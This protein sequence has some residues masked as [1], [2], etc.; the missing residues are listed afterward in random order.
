MP[1]LA[2]LLQ[3]WANDLRIVGRTGRHASNM[4]QLV[5]R[6]AGLAGVTRT[7]EFT[8][9]RAT[10]ALGTLLQRGR[11]RRTVDS[12]RQALHAFGAW[13][14]R[15]ERVEKSPWWNLPRLATAADRTFRRRALTDEEI[16]RLLAVAD[17]RGR[18][19]WYR[20]GLLAGL[21]RSEIRW[22]DWSSIDLAAGILRLRGKARHRVDEL[23]LHPEILL[24]LLRVP[25]LKRTGRVFPTVPSVRTRLRDFERAGIP[26]KDAQGRIADLHA[27]RTTLATR[28]AF[29]AVPPI[30]TM[31]LLRHSR[32]ET[33]LAHYVSY[34][35]DP[36]REA[37]ARVPMPHAYSPLQEAA[38]VLG[39]TVHVYAF[40]VP[41]SG[42]RGVSVVLERADGRAEGIDLETQL[43]VRS[44]EEILGHL[45]ALAEIAADGIDDPQ[46]NL[47]APR[48]AAALLAAVLNQTEM[49]ELTRRAA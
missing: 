42:W 5:L 1:E 41:D 3:V 18:G 37:L 7:E 33:T 24:R 32:I 16:S 38:S 13:L 14:C 27:L 29:S 4:E 10:T 28:L 47:S 46:A 48:A 30:V 25:P 23:P 35:M 19:L 8:P 15:T 43:E 22:L 34:Q 9:D 26:R 44:P 31:R 2:S 6:L 45:C 36:L 11:T 20:F 49:A 40:A 12:Y 21:R 39:L 17:A